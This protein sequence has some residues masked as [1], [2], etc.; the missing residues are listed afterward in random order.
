[1]G[2]DDRQGSRRRYGPGRVEETSIS[3]KALEE[4]I[5]LC[6]HLLRSHYPGITR[7]ELYSWDWNE[8]HFALDQIGRA[9][10]EKRRWG[11]MSQLAGALAGGAQTPEAAKA[12]FEYWNDLMEAATSDAER[13][14][15]YEAEEERKLQLLEDQRRQNSRAVDR[16]EIATVEAEYQEYR[17]RILSNPPQRQADAPAKP[18]L[19]TG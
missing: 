13:E 9:E 8:V 1:V 15:K 3:L 16:R 14:E 5:D 2:L 18:R 17:K 10:R 12:A 19:S 11:L 7:Q 4:H 6:I